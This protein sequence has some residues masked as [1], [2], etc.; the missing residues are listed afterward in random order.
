MSTATAAGVGEAVGQADGL[1]A[2][3]GGVESPGDGPQQFFRGDWPHRLAQV[4]EMMREMSLQTDPQAMVR[5][6]TRRMRKFVPVDAFLS[7]S[8]RGLK[9]PWFRVTRSSTWQGEINP[10]HEQEKLPLISGGLVGELLYGDEPRI[11][12]ELEF[13]PDDPA[14]AYLAGHRS[15]MALPQFDRGEALNM[16]FQLSKEPAR[17]NREQFPEWVW[18]SGLFGRATHSLVLSEQLK[19]AYEVVEREM[20]IVAD[21]QRTL[22]PKKL[23]AV[24]G[25]DLAAHYQTSQWAGGDYYDL[26]ALPDGRWGL[27]IADVSGHGTPAAVMMAV[28]HSIAH[29][30]PGDPL[31]PGAMLDFIN[32]HLATRYTADFEAFVTAFYGIYDPAARTLTYASAG[33]NPPRL[34]R[35]E[36]GKMMSLDGVGNLPL[37]I[38]ASVHYE[39]ATKS[40][41]PG[42]Q[43]IFYTDGI[44]EAVAPDDVT[45]FGVERLDHELEN[46]H[47]TA[48]GLIHAVLAAVDV[49]TAGAPSTDDRTLLV[50]KVS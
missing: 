7:V 40:L 36:D 15:L 9:R 31:R 3:S 22:L 35:C 13:A 24:P 44:T 45:M 23:P 37:G 18:L 5:A 33:H 19:Q 39:E 46:C 2:E 17:F 16:S 34:K 12:D 11:I 20:K 47:L 8:R 14:A 38:D 1:E 49:F 4:V 50:A 10:W 29:T 6:Y 48:D 32:H 27:L 43:I 41:R 28:T 25:L 26:F 42:D 30:Y 21:L